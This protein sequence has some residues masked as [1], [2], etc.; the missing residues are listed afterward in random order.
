MEGNAPVSLITGVPGW[1]S[2]AEEAEMYT[3]AKGITSGTIL[4]IGSEFGRS[5]SLWAAAT[6]PDVAI[7][8]LD[9]RFDGPLAEI[10][11]KNLEEAGLG[12]RTTRVSGDSKA[13]Y[14][15]NKFRNRKLDL[16]FVDGDHSEA[17]AYQDLAD[18][19]PKVKKGGYVLIH[20]CAVPTNKTPHP[21]HFDVLNAVSSWQKEV[22]D[23]KLIK[24]VDSLMV[25]KRV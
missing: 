22:V 5:A 25:F 2:N 21:V 20:D 19:T 3:L 13:I 18:W 24:T 12:G 6:T 11:R 14:N 1:I 4:E 10:H 17:G 15:T 16:L 9:I 23:F 8:C 7:L